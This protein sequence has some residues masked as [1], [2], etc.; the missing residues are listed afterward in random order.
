MEEI[1][2]V[3]GQIQRAVANRETIAQLMKNG[4]EKWQS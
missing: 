3:N 4:E 2:Q 1:V